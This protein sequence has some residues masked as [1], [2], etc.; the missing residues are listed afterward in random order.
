MGKWLTGPT[1]PEFGGHALTYPQITLRPQ[2][3]RAI[4]EEVL[5]RG[6]SHRLGHSL[7]RRCHPVGRTHPMRSVTPAVPLLIQLGTPRAGA[8]RT[9]ALVR[10]HPRP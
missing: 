4:S 9:P 8:A 7:N 3:N 1:V 6:R 5:G 2:P 10:A